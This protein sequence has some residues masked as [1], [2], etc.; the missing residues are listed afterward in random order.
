M[1]S[2][3]WLFIW[4][5][6]YLS[7]D[8]YNVYEW[9]CLLVA[10]HIHRPYI[11]EQHSLSPNRYLSRWYEA[12]ICPVLVSSEQLLPVATTWFW[13]HFDWFW[14]VAFM[15]GVHKLAQF[16]SYAERDREWNPSYKR[17][18][19]YTS[20]HRVTRWL[21]GLSG[22]FYNAVSCC[23]KYCRSLNFETDCKLVLN[24][25]Q[26]PW[27]LFIEVFVFLWQQYQEPHIFLVE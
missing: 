26:T 5:D 27:P 2:Y 9:H 13:R 19:S 7:E 25:P 17:T 14:A 16:G 11:I 23:Q 4:E 21:G 22:A 10:K 24:G 15:E 6:I 1:C 3:I 8:W 20:S 18:G 12:I